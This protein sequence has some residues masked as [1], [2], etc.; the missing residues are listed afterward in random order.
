MKNRHTIYSL[1]ISVFAGIYLS[2]CATLGSVY[3][4]GSYTIEKVD[5]SLPDL[6]ITTN[7]EEDYEKRLF[8]PKEFAIKSGSEIVIN[9]TQF[10]K[11]GTPVGLIVN[12]G[13]IIYPA[14]ERYA[15]IAFFKEETGWRA[16]IFD[17]QEEII[18]KYGTN[19]LPALAMG[20]F[21]TILRDGIEYEFLDRKDYRTAVAL[22]D[23]GKTLL[24]LVGKKLSFGDCAEIFKEQGADVA[25][26]F[27]GGSSSQMVV[28]GRNVLPGVKKRVPAVMGFRRMC[29][30]VTR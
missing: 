14:V 16:E 18:E 3:N 15:G 8:Y 19:E 10:A 25:M 29:G 30:R 23:G 28:N 20:G 17:S 13:K 22:C 2:S 5:L 24:I 21:W 4:Q 26:E 12:N 9:T 11:D 1:I 7:F 6:Q 27:D